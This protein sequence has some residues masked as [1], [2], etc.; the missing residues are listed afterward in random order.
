MG[1][2]KQEDP[3]LDEISMLTG[4]LKHLQHL[5]PSDLCTPQRR[6]CEVAVDSV[7]T[8]L[9]VVDLETPYSAATWESAAVGP[10][11]VNPNDNQDLRCGRP[12]TA[13]TYA[14]ECEDYP[15]S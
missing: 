5:L 1:L 9:D 10:Q 11:N 3:L 13:H 6:R 12:L 8:R 4:R 15:I 7:S 14:T 2:E